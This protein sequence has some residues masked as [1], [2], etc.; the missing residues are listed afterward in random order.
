VARR[1]AAFC[2]LLGVLGALPAQRASAVALPPS[3]AA[4]KAP[5]HDSTA[6]AVLRKR[7]EAA[8][9]SDP[10]AAFALLCTTIPRVE[11]RYGAH[12]GELAWWTASLATP[13]IAYMD[14]FDEALPLL[15]FA[16]PILERRHGRYGEPLG[17]IHV[18]YAWIYFRQGRLT[19]SGREWSEALEVRERFPGTRKI[20]LQ[21]VLVGLAQVQLSERE[22]IHAQ[23]NLDRAHE[24]LVDNQDTVSEA[25]A[26]IESAL[27]AVEL[28]QER[29]EEARR[30]A[31]ETLRIEDRL[32]GG[33]AQLVPAYAML[34]RILERLDEYEPAEAALRH[35]VGLAEGSQGPL[36]RHHFS[37][38]YQLAALLDE[39]NRPA[40]ARTEALR[41]L[42]IGKAALGPGAPRLVPV[43]QVLGDAEHRLGELS[44]A[45]LHFDEAG[46]IIAAHGS[47]VERPW[48]V[49]YY[50]DLASLQADLGDTAEAARAIAAGIAAAGGDPT[51]AVEH[52][53]LLIDLA[54]I[55]EEPGRSAHDELTTAVTL[56]R[57]KLPESHPA[58][59]RALDE[60]CELELVTPDAAPDCAKT[61]EGFEHAT[62]VAPDLAATVDVTLSRWAAASADA[63]T[64]R[65][66]ALRAVAAAESA[67]EPERLRLAES[68]LAALL[69]ADHQSALAVFFG[70]QALMEIQRERAQLVGVDRRFEAGFLRSKVQTYREVADW[71]L[72]LGR[73][74]EGLAI[75]QL[76]KA[77]EY[78]EFGI[79]AASAAGAAVPFTP[80]EQAVQNHYGLTVAGDPDTA[81]ELS[82]LTRLEEADK[83]S[84]A[85]RARLRQLAAARSIAERERTARLDDLLRATTRADHGVLHQDLEFATPELSRL[86]GTFGDDAA[87]GVYLLVDQHLRILMTTRGEQ[88][89]ISIPVDGPQFQKEIGH[90]LDD[91]SQHHAATG[92]SRMYDLIARPI[93]EFAAKRHAH[94]LVLWLDG[95][96]H[97]LPVAAL[98]DG[99]RFLGEKYL[100][101]I[102]TPAP[103][104]PPASVPRAGRGD[105]AARQPERGLVRGFGVTQAFTGFS[106]LPAVADELCYVVDGPIAGLRTPSAACPTPSA[107][108][109]ALAGEGFADA[110]F[111]EKRFRESLAQPRR[112]SVLHIGTHFRLR[113]GN[114]LRSYL[115][116]GDGSHLSLD[117]IG[118]MD[119]GG[120]DVVTLSACET[121][122]GAAAGDDGREVEGLGA[123][124]Q[125][126]GARLVIASLWPVEDTSTAEFMRALYDGLR[127]SNGDAAFGLQQAQRRLRADRAAYGD[128]YYWAGFSVYGSTIR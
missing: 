21:K 53:R 110:E 26:A 117:E 101:Q 72:E 83:A 120:L 86:A 69:H 61:T 79:R 75:L 8:N 93:D 43:L 56:L 37:A 91:I 42:V 35:A 96:L 115:L 19:E 127:L 6:I 121:G 106:A 31:E 78:Q 22:F 107:G 45:L 38:L 66:F 122:M 16:R 12:S 70:K 2:L 39:R 126:R 44:Q 109:G 46:T 124:V 81:I 40:E 73:T 30:H 87:F 103:P 114:A 41:A 9:E 123:L 67:G 100:I 15:E 85:E 49:D 68:Q 11:R 119:F 54:H 58:I 55:G 74:D 112:F 18:A 97:Y 13:L 33:A 32:K 90:F 128:P 52:A 27:T 3:C 36:Q 104:A 7:V 116:L 95:A 60:L 111:T 98:S 59:L 102:Y 76:M 4:V 5:A 105:S 10:M 17:D 94:R 62:D 1:R 118:R 23:R 34:G 92:Q 24:I 51:L 80:W 77:E 50:R 48:L 29:Y 64:A 99:R 82:Q 63:P 65:N 14:K 89:E 47:D 57:S 125:Q 113:P 25:G 71:L 108:H 20:E 84:A 28:R 88:R